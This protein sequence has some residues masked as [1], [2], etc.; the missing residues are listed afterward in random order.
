MQNN[1]TGGQIPVF[2]NSNNNRELTPVIVSVIVGA[3]GMASVGVFVPKPC[4]A[5]TV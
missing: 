1:K 5:V 4:T 3:L 2:S